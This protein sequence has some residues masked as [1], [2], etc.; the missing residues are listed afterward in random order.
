MCRYK[1]T[2]AEFT[3]TSGI[4]TKRDQKALGQVII[5]RNLQTFRKWFVNKEAALNYV[6][7]FNKKLN[8]SYTVRFSTDK[9][10]GMAKE[11]DNYKIEYTQKQLQEV[12][13]IG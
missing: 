5:K 11:C 10:F 3:P 7:N 1:I 4:V 8:K 12:Y 13:T 9:Q 2:W 6:K